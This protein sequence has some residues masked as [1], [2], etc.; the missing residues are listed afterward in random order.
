[1]CLFAVAGSPTVGT[2]FQNSCVE[3]T[4]LLGLEQANSDQV[5][6]FRFRLS[7]SSRSL[8][9]RLVFVTGIVCF[10]LE[11]DPGQSGLD[12]LDWISRSTGRAPLKS[13][14]ACLCVYIYMPS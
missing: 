5:E 13:I 14:T 4:I 12:D 11:L 6:M 10:D 9:F 7:G 1:M 2:H 8:L 3:I